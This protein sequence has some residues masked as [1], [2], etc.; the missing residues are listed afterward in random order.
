MRY[1]SAALVVLAFLCFLLGAAPP[2]HVR[3]GLPAP[4]IDQAIVATLVA[5]E[6]RLTGSGLGI[7]PTPR[8]VVFEFGAET[9][10]VGAE[11][12][13]ITMWTSSEVRIALPPAVR[14]G[15]LRILVDG[16]S[17]APVDVE[18]FEYTTF[19][20][21]S[22]TGESEF[23]L[24]LAVDPSGRVWVNKEAHTTL[25][26]LTPAT[27][28]SPAS[29]GKATIPQAAGPGI[30][31]S[32]PN[33]GA[34]DTQTRLS[35]LGEDI[36]VAS[37]GSVWFTEGGGSLYV[38]QHFNTS[39]IVRYTPSTGQFA[40]FAVPVDD[41]EVVALLIDEQRDLVWYTEGDFVN[42]NSI[43]SFHPDSMTGDCLWD[44]AGSGARP[45]ICEAGQ[46]AG[47]HDRHLLPGT[48]RMPA[49]LALAPD[50]SIW[51]AE[52]WA[53][54]IGRLDPG[55]RQ[56]TEFPMP[57]PIVR[58]GPGIYAGSG[59]W[60]LGF[61][62][63]GD[64]WLS[65]FYDAT[66]VRFRPSLAD[67]NDCTQLAPDGGNPCVEEVFVDSDGYDNRALHTV[68]PTSSGRVWFT[69]AD[70]L[71]YVSTTHGTTVLTL[72]GTASSGGL[73]GLAANTVTGEV[74]VALFHDKKVGRI[75]LAQGDGDGV[76]SVVD[77]CPSAYNPDQAN[78]DRNFVDLSA[79]GYPF[80]DLT[81]PQSDEMGDACD[82]DADNDGLANA[83]ENDPIASGCPSASGAT[84]ALLRDSDG[85][86]VLDGA[87]CALGYDPASASS[88]P[89]NA[90][91][92]DI[93][94]D[95]LPDSIEPAIGADPAKRDTDG[96][97][98]SDGIEFKFYGSRPNSTNSDADRCA[99]GYEVASID[100]NIAVNSLD[101]LLIVLAFGPSSGPKYVPQ[102]DVNRDGGINSGDMFTLVILFGLCKSS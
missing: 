67:T 30:F 81:W 36:D 22:G 16:L 71:S 53:S 12:A 92:G 47:C 57:A 94:K 61:D 21:P 51:F 42:G 1:A 13:N 40:C 37:D 64:L 70:G 69:H 80:N 99:D 50:G 29:T 96:D 59:P 88:R 82:M 46:T 77:N 3:A 19:P 41:A 90:P 5:G 63:A 76:D 55:T 23:P 44:P 89:P 32:K 35:V 91:A 56:I 45:A 27:G 15:Q 7:D 8:S 49:H 48:F 11:S 20:L 102:F 2:R 86:L 66:V 54:R 34:A 65:E 28:T 93:D 83:T 68:L 75:R 52:Y 85:D 24:A 39:R 72:T 100:G 78:V 101:Q 43:T 33:N 84:N 87:E 98:I 18:V 31:A 26:W 14:T 17:S 60:E 10:V 74:W 6:V 38:G 73:S 25:E 4:V 9:V 97:K 79:W 62:A 95:G 58:I